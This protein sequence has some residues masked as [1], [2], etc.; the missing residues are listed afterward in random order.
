MKNNIYKIATSLII[1]VIIASCASTKS[2]TDQPIIDPVCGMKVNKSESFDWKY[3]GKKYYFDSY[4]CREAFKSDP[5]KYL[6]NKCTPPSKTDIDLV[7]G[8]KVDKSESYDWKYK[9]KTYYFHSNDCRESFKMNPEKFI[10]NI[11]APK[12]SIK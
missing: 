9:E 8:L 3:D 7:C 5:K 10:K 2:V 6:E 1:A 11:C 12:D 4:D